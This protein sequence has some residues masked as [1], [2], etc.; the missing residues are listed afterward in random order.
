MAKGSPSMIALLGL[1]A[2][3]GYQNR[4]KLAGLLHG[5]NGTADPQQ[6][7]DGSSAGPAADAHAPASGGLMDDL[8]RMV[9]G[10]GGGGVTGGLSEILGRFT[11]PVQAAKARS[12]VDTGPNGALVPGDLEQVLDDETLA[13]LSQKTGLSRADLLSRLSTVLPEAVDQFT[14]D[15]HMPSVAYPRP[16]T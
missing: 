10:A 8:R 9:S 4:D 6:P 12:W 15:G 16:V 2:V 5:A 1:L 13:D 7:R 14:P 3:A 11:N